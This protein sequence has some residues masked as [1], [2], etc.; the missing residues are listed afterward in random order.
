MHRKG[1]DDV[2][3]IR[4]PSLRYD[5]DGIG[6]FFEAIMALTIVT[7]GVLLLTLSMTLLSVD[8]GDGSED[9]DLRCESVLDSILKN[10]AWSR[11]SMILDQRGLA[12]ADWTSFLEEGGA[13][14]MLTYPDGTTHVLHQQGNITDGERSSRSAPVNI[15]FNQADVRAA[16]ITVWVWA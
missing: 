2:R 16:L 10:P 9:L 1:E 14:I 7:S 13:K 15:F 6:G 5:R 11:G 3:L 4:R 8:D 12:R